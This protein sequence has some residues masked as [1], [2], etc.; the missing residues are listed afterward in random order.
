MITKVAKKPIVK[1]SKSNVSKKPLSV[2]KKKSKKVILEVK[3][4]K[5][6]YGKLKVLKGISFE[7]ME[8]E[9]VAL[10]GANGAGKSTLT[11]II[12]QVKEQ[13]SGEIKYSFGET[14]GEISKN[15]GIQFQESTYPQFYKSIDIIDFFL[16]ASKAKIP[17]EELDKMMKIFHL[18]DIKDKDAEGLSGGQ[19]Q[20]LNIL[21]A[22]IHNPRLL[23]LDEVSTGLDIEAREDIKNYI[24]AYLNETK[25]TLLLVSHNPDE[26]AFLTD[27]ILVIKDGLLY[28]DILMKNIMKKFKTFDEYITDLFINKFKQERKALELSKTNKKEEKK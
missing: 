19:K 13:S 28:Q 7:L 6:N 20:R 5:K 3:D 1:K 11:E 8:G 26:I 4:I 2:S 27:R 9:R 15:I 23:L 25:A 14:K 22:I 21:L 12:S 18:E 10:I 16:G 17:Q 24:K